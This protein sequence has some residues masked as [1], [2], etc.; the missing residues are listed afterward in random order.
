MS[1]QVTPNPTQTF[2]TLVVSSTSKDAADVRVFDMAG[3][4]IEQKRGAVG[5]SIRFGSTYTQ[6]MYIVQV[7]Q[8]TTQKLMK[9]I[10]N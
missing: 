4:Q 6:G 5:E 3:R 10:K 7:I 1:I 9:V 2:F 8:G